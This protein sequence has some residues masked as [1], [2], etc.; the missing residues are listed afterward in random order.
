MYL[1]VEDIHRLME[2]YAPSRYME[3]YDNVG[4]MVGDMDDEVT[5]ILVALDCTMDVIEE[6]KSK[7]CNLVLCHHPLLFNKPSSI[8]KGDLLGKKIIKLISDKINVYSSHTNLDSVSGGLND[9]VMKLLGFSKTE[10]LDSIA[11]DSNSGL[12]RIA[13][14]SEPVQLSELCEMVKESLGL[15]SIRYTG[16]DDKSISKIAVINGSGQSHFSEAVKAGAECII[17][18]DTTYHYV[19]DMNEVGVGVIDAGHYGTEWP[20]VKVFANLLQNKIRNLGF[21]NS[22]IIAESNVC[23]YKY[24]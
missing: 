17:T 9:I 16:R 24:R 10:V 3:S 22:V 13:S 23:P 21:D 2:K 15:A 11:E 1:K 5:S 19:S 7:R 18:G 6:A 14:L 12:G 4:L 8:T 20:A